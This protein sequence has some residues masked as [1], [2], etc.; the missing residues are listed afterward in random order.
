M[1]QITIDS[2]LSALTKGSVPAAVL[3]EE[4]NYQ[5]LLNIGKDGIGQLKLH[6]A[7]GMV[8]I[9]D[10]KLNLPALQGQL[11]VQLSQA[12]SGKLQLK[13]SQNGPQPM[14][15]Q[16]TQPQLQQLVTQLS[17]QLSSPQATQS[18]TQ[19]TAQ[20]TARLPAQ[21]TS[22]LQPQQN[23]SSAKVVQVPV[24]IQRLEQQLILQLGQNK[25]QLPLPAVLQSLPATQWLNAKLQLKAGQLSLVLAKA[26]LQPETAGSKAA[27]LPQSKTAS[28][29]VQGK[30]TELLTVPL[31]HETTSGP[32]KNQPQPVVV[33]TQHQIQ[34]QGPAQTQPQ[35]PVQNQ[36]KTQ[37]NTQAPAALQAQTIIPLPATV[38]QRI[39]P[40]VLPALTTAVSGVVLSLNEL[41]QLPLPAAMKQQLA[42]PAYQLQL[43]PQGQ[44]QLKA[45]PE[46]KTIQIEPQPKVLQVQS[47]KTA[48][49]Q[50]ASGTVEATKVVK[51]AIEPAVLN[52]AWR[53]LLPM[54]NPEWENLAEVPELPQAVKAILQLVRQSQPDAS[55]MTNLAQLPAQ[56]QALLQFNPLQNVTMPQ[57]A[58]GTLAVAIQLLLGRLGQSLPQNDKAV[59]KDHKLKEFVAQLDQNQSSQLLKQLSSQSSSLQH[60]QLSTLEQ[61]SKDPLQQLFLTLPI[62]NQQVSDFCQIAI[63]QQEEDQ[64][65]GKGKST[66]WQLSMKF[67]LKQLGQLLAISKLSGNSLALQLY[68][69]TT[70]LKLLAEKYL[71]LLKDRCKAQGIEVTEAHCQL[72]KIPDTLMPKTT[73]LLAIRV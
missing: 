35:V 20:V 51:L 63:T 59:N 19:L 9:Q 1:N 22:Q 61:Q 26:A 50:T 49:P 7:S 73:S 33:K 23:S 12:L 37:I 36:S 56:L 11:M 47:A 58:A 67:D 8:L 52:Q 54:L 5:A 65:K 71:P 41:K 45:I 55:K 57:T 44:L 28:A 40:L 10:A 34:T 43:N 38:Q 15:V 2:A 18:P 62:Q 46:Q 32:V 64:D 27:D 68:T 3:V 16:L 69:D 17:S 24:Q 60:A 29:V 53:Q 39:L 31:K 66:Q 21:L 4:Q 25:V 6:T 30:N 70:V 14:P 48:Q 72:G 13:L 42:D